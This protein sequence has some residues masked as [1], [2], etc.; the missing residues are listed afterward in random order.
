MALYHG[1]NYLLLL[2]TMSPKFLTTAHDTE[3]GLIT[4]LRYGGKEDNELTDL[5]P[6]K[7]PMT[8]VTPWSLLPLLLGSGAHRSSVG[9]CVLVLSTTTDVSASGPDVEDSTAPTRVND[10]MEVDEPTSILR[11]K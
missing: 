1:R 5:T 2:F 10:H 3:G 11:E 9:F 8:Y 4:P 6:Q 7:G